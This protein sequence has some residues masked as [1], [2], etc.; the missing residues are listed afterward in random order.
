VSF[1]DQ[2]VSLRGGVSDKNDHKDDET[3]LEDPEAGAGES[4]E[5]APGDGVGVGVGASAGEDGA[6]AGADGA[7]P[8][9]VVDADMID[10]KERATTLHS[11]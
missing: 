11:V 6:D 7:G 3:A 1:S 9:S 2:R 10:V 4:G 5:A 8:G